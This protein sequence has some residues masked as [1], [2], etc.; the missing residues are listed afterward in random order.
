VCSSKRQWL[1]LAGIKLS[2]QLMNT[3]PLAPYIDYEV[4]DG[5]HIQSGKELLD[6]DRQ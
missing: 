5:S 2:R 3:E 6:I 1:L 4:Y